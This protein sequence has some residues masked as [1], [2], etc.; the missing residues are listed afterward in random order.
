MKTWLSAGLVGVLALGCGDDGDT[1]GTT[2]QVPLPP[3]SVSAKIENDNIVLSWSA[4][5]G[6]TSYNVYMAAEAGVKRANVATLSGNMSHPDLLAKFDHPPGLDPSIKWFLVVTAENADGE[7]AE[8]CE[9][10]ATI[11]TKVGGT[12]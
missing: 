2:K 3:A 8:S 9:V 4:V 7:S 10:T 11:N 5:T 1:T 6:A 12:C